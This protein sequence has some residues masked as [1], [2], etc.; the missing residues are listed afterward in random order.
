MSSLGDTEALALRPLLM[1]LGIV[2][3]LGKGL[4]LSFGPEQKLGLPESFSP[5]QQRHFKDCI[6]RWATSLMALAIV[7]AMVE[8]CCRIAIWLNSDVNSHIMDG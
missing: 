5:D 2:H 4:R 1:V 7:G 6:N 3:C 8:I